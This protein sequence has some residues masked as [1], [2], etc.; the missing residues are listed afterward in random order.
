MGILFQ[1]EANGKGFAIRAVFEFV[2]EIESN[3]I[4]DKIGLHRA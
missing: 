2:S 3:C 1:I 4:N